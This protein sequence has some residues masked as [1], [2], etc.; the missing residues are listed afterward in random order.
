MVRV[1]RKTAFA[2]ALGAVTMLGACKKSENAADTTVAAAD[3]SMSAGAGSST[4][5][6]A[7]AA[8]PAPVTD[9]GIL[10]TLA[11]ANQGEID[12]GK[13]AESKATSASVKSF[14]HDM[15]V[16]HTAMLK[17]GDALA[18]KLNITPDAAAADSINAMNQST[19][20]ALS[21]AAKGA[22]FDSAYVNAQVAGH[23]YVLDM[24]KRDESAAQNAELKSALTAAE[25]KVQAHLDRIKAIQ[26]KMM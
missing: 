5:M 12:A 23:Q 4:S 2:L 3:T 25:P 16:A 10:A 24:I 17:S 26:G 9:A 20:A 18:K 13:L 7:A 22:A 1:T 8:A 14:A 21:A 6:N 11:A 19:G 15:V